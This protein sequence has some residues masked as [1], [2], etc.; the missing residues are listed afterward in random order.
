MARLLPPERDISVL[1]APV[2]SCLALV[3]VFL[4]VLVALALLERLGL[5]PGAALTGAIG[6]AF[7]LLAFAAL[8]AH[9]RR[10]IDFYVADRKVTGSFGGLVGAIGFAGLLALGLAGGAYTS[11]AEFLVAVAGFAAGYLI[12]AVALAPGLRGLG[13]YTPGDFLAARFGGGWI[14]LAWAAVAFTVS[15]LLLIAQLKLAGPLLSRLFGLSE[16]NGLYAAA[17]LTMITALPGGM[18]SLAWTQAVQY[19]VV[20]FAC[21]M[22][23]GFLVQSGPPGE[24]AIAENLDALFASMPAVRAAGMQSLMSLFLMAIGTASL[25]HLVSRVLTASPGRAAR[26]S[27]AWGV[28]FA[29]V[30]IVASLALSELLAGIALPEP[31]GAPLAQLAERL[32][33]LPGVLVGLAFAGVLAALL[34]LGQAV[35]FAAATA[36][37]HDVW[38]EIVDRRG[39][40]GRRIVVARLILVAVAA[41]AAA[42]APALGAGPADLLDWA[43]ALAA[44]AGFVPLALGLWWRRCTEIGTLGGMVTGFVFTGLVFLIEQQFVSAA[45]LSRGWVGLGAPGAAAVG[46]TGALVIAVGLSL[47]TRARATSVRALAERGANP[48]GGPPIR[49]RPA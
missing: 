49:E 23:A 40:E 6:A 11:E 41:A 18:R 16:Q 17:A 28:V 1:N 15:F 47:V 30:L 31:T 34:A 48:R 10:A 22:V 43:L 42:L 45:T 19:F 9:S 7:A 21:V 29:A 44:A 36:L 33:G 13:A 32:G 24:G 5:E 27:M 26:G 25:P 2:R 8:L 37:S 4:L 14:R 3:S 35:L 38:D 39:A 12:L 20:A 46:L